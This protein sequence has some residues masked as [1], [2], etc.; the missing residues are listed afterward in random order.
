MFLGF[1]HSHRRVLSGNLL[2]L[3]AVIH[4]IHDC[5]DFKLAKLE[6]LTILAIVSYMY[7]IE[8]TAK[9]TTV[10]ILLQSAFWGT[11]FNFGKTH[12]N[13]WSMHIF[14]QIPLMQAVPQYSLKLS[15]Y[16]DCWMGNSG[17]HD[18]TEPTMVWHTEVFQH[19]QK[20]LI[21]TLQK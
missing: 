19:A 6:Q 1:S 9:L 10:K 16:Q 2:C 21:K 20:K 15:S 11:W 3:K 18:A 14:W 17:I 7:L 12:Q 4:V 8:T 13:L 5:S